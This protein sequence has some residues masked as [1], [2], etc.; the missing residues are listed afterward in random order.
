[1]GYTLKKALGSTRGGWEVKVPGLRV[2]LDCRA[3][4]LRGR[5][6][7]ASVVGWGLALVGQSGLVGCQRVQPWVG[8]GAVC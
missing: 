6:E 4:G 5:P 2:L 1:M 8:Q 3:Q 7:V